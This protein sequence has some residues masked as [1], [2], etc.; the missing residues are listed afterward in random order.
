MSSATYQAV[1]ERLDDVLAAP[2]PTR[3]PTKEHLLLKA[4]IVAADKRTFEAIIST[5]AVD[6][7][8]DIVSTAGMVEALRA[9]IPL[10]KLI[11]LAWS[12]SSAPEDVI[13]HI[14]PASAKAVDGEVH[15]AGWID[16]S[17][18]RG[19]ETWR[20]VKSGTLGF[21]FGYLIVDAVKRADGVREIHELD[22]FE[23]SACSTPMN[24]ATRVTAW[25]S[26]DREPMSLEE[27]RRLEASLGLDENE[28]RRQQ[29]AD[30]FVALMRTSDGL[31]EPRQGQG[32]PRPS[33]QGRTR[34]RADR[35]RELRCL[36][37]TNNAGPNG[38]EPHAPSH[39]DPPTL[40]ASI[41]VMN[42][43]SMRPHQGRE[44]GAMER[45]ERPLGSST[46]RSRS[47]TDPNR[48]RDE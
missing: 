35:G 21:S 29:T 13:G 36:A 48:P 18:P 37:A 14:D 3:A 20:R 23:V 42:A 9:S 27:L 34:V 10:G 1:M 4:A 41:V 26:A 44:S 24:A 32:A 15:A 19:Q 40:T 16:Q 22:V 8:R 25:K 45:P 2:V 43:P 30:E 6:R 38:S 28:Q 47:R 5:E 12:H 17:I 46:Q 33:G 31:H 39:H 7:E 11:P